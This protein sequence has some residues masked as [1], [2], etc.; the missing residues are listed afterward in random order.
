MN[1][2]ELMTVNSVAKMTGITI[3]MLHY[4]DQI[5]LLSP[6]CVSSTKYRFYSN[7]DLDRLQQ[8]LFFK[9][10]GFNLKEIKDIMSAPVYNRE[11][12]LKKHVHILLLKR[13]RID[14]LIELIDK[15]LKGESKINLSEF[16]NQAIIIYCN[17]NTDNKN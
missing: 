17:N 1:K 4:Y 12:A 16:V 11:E 15:A 14:E 9:E 5:K 7:E 13:K 3:R 8:I 2:D 10:A 6:S